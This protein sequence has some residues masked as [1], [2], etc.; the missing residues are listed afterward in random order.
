MGIATPSYTP[1]PLKSEWAKRHGK[2]VEAARLLSLIAVVSIFPVY[3]QHFGDWSELV[4]ANRQSWGIND[5]MLQVQRGMWSHGQS[6]Y[7]KIAVFAIKN[8]VKGC[9]S[10]KS[11]LEA[12]TSQSMSSL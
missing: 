8:I 10:K 4:T 9:R 3:Y 11:S 5:F 6:S 7:G 1:F 2:R 12:T